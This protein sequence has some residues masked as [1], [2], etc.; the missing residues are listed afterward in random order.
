MR[1]LIAV[2][3][4]VISALG[5]FSAAHA[6]ENLEEVQAYIKKN[7]DVKMSDGY[8]LS[9][10]FCAADDVSCNLGAGQTLKDMRAAY[11]K[12]ITGQRNMGSC[13]RSGCDGGVQKNLPLA[14]AW[15]IIVLASGNPDISDTD[16]KYLKI[17]L[18][19]LDALGI[20]TT[21]AQAASLFRTIY[22]R[23]ISPDWQ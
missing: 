21:K 7:R 13:L 4:F 1:V 8:Q 14:C 11:K 3:F 17:C 20:A 23:E 16:A 18:G 5:I 15:R 19:E 10:G 9:L 12:D 6:F 2:I 22:K